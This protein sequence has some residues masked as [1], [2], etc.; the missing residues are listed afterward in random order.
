MPVPAIFAAIASGV[1]AAVKAAGSVAAVGGRL[2]IAG[3][4]AAAGGVGRA[5]GKMGAGRA[6]VKAGGRVGTVLEGTEGAENAREVTARLAAMRGGTQGGSGAGE[7]VGQAVGQSPKGPPP[8]A[9]PSSVKGPAEPV[10]KPRPGKMPGTEP[11]GRPSPSGPSV[12]SEPGVRSGP[13]D[14][15]L[16]GLDKFYEQMGVS[17]GKGSE[18]A[19]T[20]SPKPPRPERSQ[21]LRLPKF[22]R[23][24]LLRKPGGEDEKYKEATVPEIAKRLGTPTPS[25]A[26]VGSTRARDK[27]Q[28]EANAAE[29]QRRAGLQSRV[30]EKLISALGW[31]TKNV[32]TLGAATLVAVTIGME[33]LGARILK[34]SENLQIYSPK[35][36]LAF[37]RLE[38]QTAV[39][40]SRQAKAT[41]GTASGLA[42]SLQQFYEVFQ[43]IRELSA[44]VANIMGS[45]LVKLAT[46]IIA[47]I[48]LIASAVNWMVSFWPWSDDAEQ[49][50]LFRETA[51]IYNMRLMTEGEFRP[52]V[53]DPLGVIRPTAGSNS[54]WWGTARAGRRRP[55]T[56]GPAGGGR[57]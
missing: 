21:G 48:A 45:G 2:A 14:R 10:A 50:P 37:Q 43:P 38:R 24:T 22:I 30:T 19:G 52:I 27:E 54:A 3:G 18:S 46:G 41:S 57:P 47:P 1:G 15:F 49:D 31:L 5:V 26:Q 44:N 35:I 36:A 6:G 39:L 29:K 20:K 56:G 55:L 40:N 53:G 11:G 28:F 13:M 25:E 23:D 4:R 16:K 12:P 9:R 33:R 34:N 7:G 8:S 51:F 32:V 42:G 17:K